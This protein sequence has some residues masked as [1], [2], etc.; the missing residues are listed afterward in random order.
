MSI[1]DQFCHVKLLLFRIFMIT[2]R[3]EAFKHNSC[4]KVAQLS[5]V[6]VSMRNISMD[7][8]ALLLSVQQKYENQISQIFID[9]RQQL[10]DMNTRLFNF[11]K[12]T[13]DNECRKF[14]QKYKATKTEYNELVTSRI[15]TINNISRE[16][17]DLSEIIANLRKQNF[18]AADPVI[19]SADAFKAEFMPTK[20]KVKSKSKSDLNSVI[21]PV[22]QKMKQLQAEHEERLSKMAHDHKSTMKSLMR[23]KNVFLTN[24]IIR[25]KPTLISLLNK[26]KTAKE[27]NNQLFSEVSHYRN[28]ESQL[29]RLFRQNF[30][31]FLA[32]YA[33]NISKNKAQIQ[34]LCGKQAA[35]ITT[36]QE[37]VTNE[38][39]MR[40]QKQIH[41]KNELASIVSQ[42]NDMKYNNEHLLEAKMGDINNQQLLI[43]ATQAE[44]KQVL[45]KE[46]QF[47][48]SI[49]KESQSNIDNLGVS[50]Q[51]VKD[52]FSKSLVSMLTSISQ[53]KQY[54]A[55]Q[56]QSELQGFS[57]RLQ[58]LKAKFDK[59]ENDQFSNINGVIST[60]NDIGKNNR[61]SIQ[62]EIEKL[63]GDLRRLNQANQTE[64][65]QIEQ[66]NQI[67]SQDYEKANNSRLE[68][69]KSEIKQGETRRETENKK[70]VDQ[71]LS[72]FRRDLA[73][74]KTKSKEAFD[75]QLQD[76]MANI[77][78]TVEKDKEQIE[79]E[80]DVEEMNRKI[81]VVDEL[82]SRANIESQNKIS[83][84]NA[85]IS[86]TEKLIRQ[87]QRSIKSET[88]EIGKEYDIKI[89][90]E[91]VELSNKIEQLSKLFDPEENKRAFAIIDQVRK[92]RN[93][94]NRAQ[95]MI[96]QRQR[97]LKQL[98]QQNEQ[99]VKKMQQQIESAK[100]G[101]KLTS[102][103]NE[104]KAKQTESEQKISE[105]TKL[106]EDDKTKMSNAITRTKK[107]F[108]EQKV[109]IE[110]KYK[111]NEK[112]FQEE[113]EFNNNLNESLT[114]ETEQKK[115]EIVDKV[116]KQKSLLIE[117]HKKSVAAIQRRI[118]S[119]KNSLSELQT[120]C[121]D[122]FDKK[123]SVLDDT[124]QKRSAKDNQYIEQLMNNSNEKNTKL[125]AEI[126]R[127]W[128]LRG[129]LVAQ[130]QDPE[131]GND[132][133]QRI[134]AKKKECEVALQKVNEAQTQFI[135]IITGLEMHSQSL[136]SIL[137]SPRT[138]K[139]GNA[140]IMS[141]HVV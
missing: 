41:M 129:S 96:N 127:L 64:I 88:E 82:I 37:E 12:A 4:K 130:S 39:R 86:N 61:K 117:E 112:M 106:L 87:H 48:E 74:K 77:L 3:N 59:Y 134:T 52:N 35:L 45:E 84:L 22:N 6:I 73:D 102:V 99:K 34:A 15:E 135:D 92:I 79:H 43:A 97:A 120:L 21:N 33:S 56:I 103:Q 67:Q 70:K 31:D 58:E 53:S 1:L 116:E 89:Q 25:R 51:V 57:K 5:K 133:K 90:F 68:G 17:K 123:K 28:S 19:H 80:K 16:A 49:I 119:V 66:K 54:E 140:R 78:K 141:P 29:I 139:R 26:I 104:F 124:L 24:E 108:D 55:N 62:T 23:E 8:A 71:V 69:R 111:E 113:T 75:K 118:E 115:Q 14:A 137:I 81:Q 13:I 109:N 76:S 121:N 110:K 132:E 91:Q 83:A 11:R 27:S 32:Q 40:Q 38:E 7:H 107:E 93:V 44:Y 101:D 9:H 10:E 65:T 30:S 72:G 128:A 95:D 105:A 36:F 2:D 47:F 126:L 18:Q 131:I 42:I 100:N 114:K 46:R 85:M 122:E 125:D 50:I 94:Q 138:R 63:Q 136:N 60:S 98:K 20:K